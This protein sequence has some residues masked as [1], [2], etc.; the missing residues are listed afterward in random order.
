ML[1]ELKLR[2]IYKKIKVKYFRNGYDMI[3][4][5]NYEKRK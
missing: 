4:N 3:Y 2:N 1:C 5:F